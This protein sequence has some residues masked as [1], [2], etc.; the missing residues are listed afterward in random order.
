MSCFEEWQ[1]EHSD[2]NAWAIAYRDLE[3]LDSAGVHGHLSLLKHHTLPNHFT[4]H[5]YL[6]SK[7]IQQ[8]AEV[9]ANSNNIRPVL[10]NFGGW[11]LCVDEHTYDMDWPA[12]QLPKD[13]AQSLS[14]DAESV[15][16][17][18]RPRME[19]AWVAFKAMGFE[20]G[21]ESWEQIAQRIERDTGEKPSHKSL[22]NWRNEYLG[23]K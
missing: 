8:W 12:C 16:T 14:L 9:S 23:R 22:R 3:H 20:K 17:R 19:K 10:E 5:A 13:Q 15:V 7:T 4:R 11:A 21:V 1:G 6:I 2:R 18:G